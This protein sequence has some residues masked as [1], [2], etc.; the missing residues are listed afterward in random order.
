MI[1]KLII[2]L[3][4]VAS[5]VSLIAGGSIQFGWPSITDT[6]V[7]SV[8]FYLT[9]GTNTVF[10]VGNT[11]ATVI[12]TVP[13]PATSAT[14]TNLGSGA[15]SAVATCITSNGLESANSNEVWTNVIPGAIVNLS[16]TGTHTP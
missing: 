3:L 10:A 9:Q 8:K 2:G 4:L 1:K 15:W 5:S 14:I 16:I 12:L 6:N 13:L 11:N 7:Q